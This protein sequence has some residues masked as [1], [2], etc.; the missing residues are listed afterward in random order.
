MNDRTFRN[1][2]LLV[3]LGLVIYWLLTRRASAADAPATVSGAAGEPGG[4]VP[5]TWQSPFMDMLGAHPG[6]LSPA[7]PVQI[8]IGNQFANLL[9][10]QYTP[11]FGVV[12][13]AQGS[14][15]Q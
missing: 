12:G 11:M 4:P 13:M 8:N 2:G 1:V 7:N 6:M 5:V 15:Y 14:L 3:A 10:N 9:S